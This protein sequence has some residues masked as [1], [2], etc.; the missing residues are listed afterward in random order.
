MPA[1]SGGGRTPVQR[2]TP[3]SPDNQGARAFIDRGR[4]LHA[5]TAQ[6][7]L[8]VILKLVIS[9]LTSVI[10]IVLG[11]VNLQFQGRFVSI[12]LRP[13]LGIVAAMSWLPS[14][15]HVVHFFHL[16]GVSVSI[17]QLTGYGS[18]YDL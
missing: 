18:E 3:P 4:G 9:G 7:A 15:H 6:P 10:S 8:T 13:V 12:S 16:A 17:R 5:E 1:T 14:G 11:T 2:P